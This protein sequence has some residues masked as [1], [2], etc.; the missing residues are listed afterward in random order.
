M[1]EISAVFSIIPE[2]KINRT[3]YRCDTKFYLEPL[4][5]SNT[6]PIKIGVILFSGETLKIYIGTIHMLD[7]D[8][9]IVNFKEV[10]KNGIHL[11]KK[12]KKG[13][14]SA[15]RI[16]RIREEVEH[17]NVIKSSEKI[18]E[19]LV[20]D[21]CLLVECVAL[22]GPAELKNKLIETPLMRQYINSSLLEVVT[23]EEIDNQ[24]VYTVYKEIKNSIKINSVQNKEMESVIKL[25]ETYINNGDDILSFGLEET[26]D[27]LNSSLLK[28]VIVTEELSKEYI[29][30]VEDQC[31]NHNVQFINVPKYTF[32]KGID[33]IGIKYY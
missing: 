28:I 29:K 24:T 20:K 4:L 18:I 8:N 16:G 14:Q 25:V 3:V 2:V 32:G 10:Y 22:A 15:Q 21:T 9:E 1:L 23:T 31:I 19:Y 11:A 30:I 6:V 12:Q 5:V 26:Y 33:I 13:G 7:T 17:S 27:L